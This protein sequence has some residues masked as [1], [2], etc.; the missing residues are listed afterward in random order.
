MYYRLRIKL[1]EKNKKWKM[2][3]ALWN[4]I[5]VEETDTNRGGI[6]ISE[7]SKY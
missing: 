4:C 2:S 1:G 3:M 7:G 5:Q 6:F